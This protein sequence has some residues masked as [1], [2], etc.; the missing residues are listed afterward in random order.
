MGYGCE[1]VSHKSWLKTP[2]VPTNLSQLH[3]LKRHEDYRGINLTS[4]ALS[5]TD[6]DRYHGFKAK[7]STKVKLGDYTGYNRE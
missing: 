1:C 7:S 4:F 6:D 2:I 3:A 5:S